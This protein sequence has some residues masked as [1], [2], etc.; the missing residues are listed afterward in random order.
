MIFRFFR[1]RRYFLQYD[2][3]YTSVQQFAVAD[4]Y[5]CGLTVKQVRGSMESSTLMLH[6]M[7]SGKTSK[8]LAHLSV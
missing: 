6:L 3:N 5:S 8:R 1:R 4:C 2:D 7:S